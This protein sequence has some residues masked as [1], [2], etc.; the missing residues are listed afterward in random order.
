MASGREGK[1][2]KESAGEELRRAI[3]DRGLETIY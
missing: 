1:Y 3:K 2:V